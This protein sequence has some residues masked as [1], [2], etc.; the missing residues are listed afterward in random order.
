MKN[1]L[2][3]LGYNKCPVCKQ[4]SRIKLF[5]DNHFYYVK[6]CK[7]NNIIGPVPKFSNKFL[8]TYGYASKKDYICKAGGIYNG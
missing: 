2:N 6:C 4:F 1:L 5:S 8:K 7:C 3:K